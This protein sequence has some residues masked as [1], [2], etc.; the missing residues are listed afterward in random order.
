MNNQVSD[1]DV[2]LVVDLDGTLIKTDLLYKAAVLL[3]K[4]NL[5]TIF[6]LDMEMKVALIL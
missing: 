4:K 5:F 6:M 2:P 3:F 1:K